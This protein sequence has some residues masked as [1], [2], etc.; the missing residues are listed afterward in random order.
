[1]TYFYSS[2]IAPLSGQSAIH[3]H[4]IQSFVNHW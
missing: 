3:N 1:M 2:K 4:N